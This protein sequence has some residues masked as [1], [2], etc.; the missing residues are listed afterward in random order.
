EVEIEQLQPAA[1]VGL[2]VAA[3]EVEIAATADVGEREASVAEGCH[4][5]VDGDAA[6]YGELLKADAADDGRAPP[7]WE[8]AQVRPRRAQHAGV[9]ARPARHLAVEI[10]VQQLALDLCLQR[11]RRAG[12]RGP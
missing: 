9:L 10:G 5:S 12:H 1:D 11:G 8:L 3:R 2:V 7:R 6:R 4:R